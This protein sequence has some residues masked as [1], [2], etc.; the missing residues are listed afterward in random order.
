MN[1]DEESKKENKELELLLDAYNQECINAFMYDDRP[2]VGGFHEDGIRE[3]ESLKKKILMY[4]NYKN[5]PKIYYTGHHVFIKDDNANPYFE[6]IDHK[7][8]L[9]KI[10]LNYSN[11]KVRGSYITTLRSKDGDREKRDYQWFDF[12]DKRLIWE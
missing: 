7:G 9:D 2:S 3:R 6:I 5:P 11:R 12:D 4:L 1:L 10:S 8:Y